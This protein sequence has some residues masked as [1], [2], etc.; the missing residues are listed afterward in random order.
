MI[1]LRRIAVVLGGAALLVPGLALPAGAHVTA[2]PDTA[3][4]EFFRTALRVG[5]G[6][7][8][9]PTTTV[10]VQIPEG[11]D[12]PRPEVVPG[13]E[14]ELVREELDQPMEGSHGEEITERVTEVAW[15]GGNLSDEQFQEF[16][17]TFRIVAGAPEVLWFPTIQECE[18][19]EERWIDIPPSVEAWD[20]AEAPAPY[21]VNATAAGGEEPAA[22]SSDED[23]GGSI[24]TTGVAAESG[25]GTDPLTWVALVAGLL[26]V[27]F[28]VGA[29]VYANRRLRTSP[30][31]S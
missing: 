6:C 13:W 21:V 19:G 26:G 9:S 17:L 25:D 12:S 2:N 29:L 1:P 8:G 3:D 5:H 14:V 16:G 27:G 31:G 10:R 20:D 28:G 15:V 30:A 7:E 24:E 23:S 22:A 4:S 18:D 11:V